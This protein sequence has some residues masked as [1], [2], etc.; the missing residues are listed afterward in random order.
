MQMS[1]RTLSTILAALSSLQNEFPTSPAIVAMVR[2][3]RADVQAYSLSLADEPD[4]WT[5]PRGF[6]D[7]GDNDSRRED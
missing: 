3:A 2:D 1:D 7:M 4:E 5:R 6:S